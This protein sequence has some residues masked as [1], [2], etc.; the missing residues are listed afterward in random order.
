MPKATQVPGKSWMQQDPET[1]L[2]PKLLWSS[3]TG[4]DGPRRPG[5]GV[6]S[7]RGGTEDRAWFRVLLELQNWESIWGAH[8]PQGTLTVSGFGHS[9]N[10]VGSGGRSEHS[11]LSPLDLFSTGHLVGLKQLL[12]P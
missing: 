2:A 12:I 8:L 6:E 9:V 11:S 1:P 10:T 3:W 4:E 7:G 5:L